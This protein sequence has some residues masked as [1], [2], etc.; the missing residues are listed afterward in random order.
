VYNLIQESREKRD[1]REKRGE[2][3]DRT[4]M[5]SRLDSFHSSMFLQ[6]L[7]GYL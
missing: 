2:G 5:S 6:I 7:H 3:R 1:S 4:E